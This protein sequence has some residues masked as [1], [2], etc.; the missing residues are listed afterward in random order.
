MSPNHRTIK[1]FPLPTAQHHITKGFLYEFLYPGT[2]HPAIKKKCQG[3][4]KGENTIWRDRVKIGINRGKD[5]RIITLGTKKKI[6]N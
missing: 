1:G 2:S 6:Y 4:A 5:I 3:I